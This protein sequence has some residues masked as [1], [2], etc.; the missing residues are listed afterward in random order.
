MA[1]L[2]KAI[3]RFNAIPVKLS[4]TIFTELKQM[5]LK[6]IWNH[7]NPRIVKAILR[8]KDKAEGITLPDFKQYYKVTVNKTMRC[9]YKNRQMEQKRE[10]RNKS[11]HLQSINL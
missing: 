1:V 5:I 7:K 6:F 4:M 8:K 3:Y 9:W 2:P 10:L 11:T